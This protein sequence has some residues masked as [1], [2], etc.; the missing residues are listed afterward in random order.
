MQSQLSPHQNQAGNTLLHVHLPNVTMHVHYIQFGGAYK[1]S[2]IVE[3][4]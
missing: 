4:Y 3:E 1:R 2:K